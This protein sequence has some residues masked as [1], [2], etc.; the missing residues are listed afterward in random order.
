MAESG[1]KFDI[2]V[3]STMERAKETAN[4]IHKEINNPELKIVLDPILEEGPPLPPEPTLASYWRPQ[5]SV[6]YNIFIFSSEK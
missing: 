5:A 4:L 6:G 3:S 2:M 1:I